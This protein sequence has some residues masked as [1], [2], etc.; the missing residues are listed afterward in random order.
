[1][2]QYFFLALVSATLFASCT[3]NSDTLF[4]SNPV[5]EKRTD[6]RMEISIQTTGDAQI[7]LTPERVVISNPTSA[8]FTVTVDPGLF[9]EQVYTAVS[10]T[11]SHAADAL[12]IT[13]NPGFY[14]VVYEDQGEVTVSP[15]SSSV[16]NLSIQPIGVQTSGYQTI[17]EED[18]GI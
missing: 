1:M 15:N 3:K 11:A 4:T 2:R 18:E 17:I 6:E 9:T 10:L 8:S 7:D 5:A 13:K 12:K 16:F 14:Q